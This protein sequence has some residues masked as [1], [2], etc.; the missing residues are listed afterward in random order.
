[1]I[2]SFLKDDFNE[3]NNIIVDEI[4]NE[5]EY[6]EN[7]QEENQNK[8]EFYSCVALNLDENEDMNNNNNNIDNYDN[9]NKYENNNNL[10]ED[11]NNV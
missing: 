11:E 8:S 4:K 1:M 6:H 9:Y 2:K 3:T 10:K 7:E 5:E